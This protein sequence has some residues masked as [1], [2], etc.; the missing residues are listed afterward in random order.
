[1]LYY[2]K[3]SPEE[4]QMT[5]SE[6]AKIVLSEM[7]KPMHV[8][9]LVKEIESRNLFKFGAKNPPAVLSGALNKNATIFERT[10]SGIYRLNN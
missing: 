8:R 9:D 3:N 1:M 7:N 10:A 5:M 2:I 4:L 6:A